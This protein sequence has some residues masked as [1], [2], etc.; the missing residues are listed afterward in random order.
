[1]DKISTEMSNQTI[2][3][4]KLI[5]HL[6]KMRHDVMVLKFLVEHVPFYTDTQ[7]Q[8]ILKWFRIFGMQDFGVAEKLLEM[9]ADMLTIWKEQHER[10]FH[11]GDFGS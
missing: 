3:L 5:T 7:K 11:E 2:Q 9:E 6:Q 8:L 10:S 1:M 4:Y